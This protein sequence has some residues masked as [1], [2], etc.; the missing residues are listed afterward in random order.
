MPLK[1]QGFLIHRAPSVSPQ[2]SL[3]VNGCREI[4][5]KVDIVDLGSAKVMKGVR[6]I[7][8]LEGDGSSPP[9]LPQR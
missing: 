5:V 4:A 2:A 9:L 1:G 3:N 6:F 7:P 8:S